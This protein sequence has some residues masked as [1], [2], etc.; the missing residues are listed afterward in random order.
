MDKRREQAEDRMVNPVHEE[1]LAEP[2]EDDENPP[3][4]Q[5]LFF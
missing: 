1:G 3:Q 4:P 5:Q 2:S